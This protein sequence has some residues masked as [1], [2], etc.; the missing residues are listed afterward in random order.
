V[1]GAGMNL[2]VA[3]EEGG[4]HTSGVIETPEI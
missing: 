2:K 4:G 3:G 1:H